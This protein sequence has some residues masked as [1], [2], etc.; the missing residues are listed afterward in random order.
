M[1][2]CKKYKIP[3][4]IIS[5]KKYTENYEG[6]NI[7]NMFEKNQIYD[8]FEKYNRILRL[9]WDVL[10]TPKCPNLFDVVPEERIGAVIEDRGSR[11][12]NRRWRIKKIQE[13]FNNIGWTSGYFNA[14][15]IV[16]SKKHREIFYTKPEELNLL[17]NIN[18]ED[19]E[20]TFLNYKIRQLGF[21]IFNLNY[22][23]NH[24][25]I[26]SEPWNNCQNRLQSYI[27]H[28]AGSSKEISLKRME[29]D[30]YKL[31]IKKKI[32]NKDIFH[33]FLKRRVK[34]LKIYKIWNDFNEDLKLKNFSFSHITKI[35]KKFLFKRIL[36]Y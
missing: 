17:K 2:Y 27:I 25:S 33:Y 35:F 14:G 20:Q 28:Y 31:F 11:K 7:F 32:K 8:L 24:M 5:E 36:K 3:L 6:N 16:A 10:I 23:F 29:L 4:E 18:V 30:Y 21:K 26:F 19:R 9:D 12:E 13:E 15:V 34:F 1:K 22:K